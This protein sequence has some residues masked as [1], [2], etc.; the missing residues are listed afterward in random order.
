MVEV[1]E[2][3][4]SVEV[5]EVFEVVEVVEAAAAAAAVVAAVAFVNALSPSEAHSCGRSRLETP[6]IVRSPVNP[7][8]SEVKSKVLD[9]GLLAMFLAAAPFVQSN[10][11]MDMRKHVCM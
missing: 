6:A 4:E 1:V 3:V 11:L 8:A 5:V 7:I 10:K 2:V 9:A